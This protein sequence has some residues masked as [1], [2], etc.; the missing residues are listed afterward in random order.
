MRG[1]HKASAGHLLALFSILVWGTTFISTKVLLVDFTPVEI[2]FIRLVI[3][4]LALWIAS[5][6][7]LR[8][9]TKKQ[10]LLFALAGLSGVT[11]YQLTENIAL[12]YTRASNV[13]LIVSIAPFFTALLSQL[14]ERGEHREK[15]SVPFVIGFVCA[16]AG[17][18]LISFGGAEVQVDPV[19]DLLALLAA[20]LWA[21]Y[22]L[23]IKRVTGLGFSTVQYT[24]RV[25]FY[26]LLFMLPALL[27]MDVR[28][29]FSRFLDPAN[30]ANLL[31]LGLCASALCFVTWHFAVNKLGV[32]T[33]SVY[34]YLVPVVTL[35]ASAILLGEALTLWA[36]AGTALTLAGLFL[37]Q[38]KPR[39]A[40]LPQHKTE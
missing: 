26:G 31:F 38:Y 27:F 36:V 18:G 7:L 3:G 39:K 37:S 24:R 25:F 20:L 13:G 30:I 22:S 2:L 33:T 16:I 17:I 14:F 28:L 21:C 1:D 11:L 8:G 19:G 6:H 32:V 4:Y 15:L 29:E 5:P 12:T 35:I 40:A 23:L 10:E 34:I 9:V